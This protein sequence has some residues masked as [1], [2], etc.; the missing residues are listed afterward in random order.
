[1]INS[2]RHLSLRVI[3]TLLALSLFSFYSC[4]K[5]PEKIDYVARVNNSYLTREEFSSLVDTSS[6]DQIKK[7]D[8][9]R[10]W[11][12]SE[13]L[14]Q[15][16]EREGI[17]KDK[18]YSLILSQSAKQLAGAMLID[19]ILRYENI[20]LDQKEVKSYFDENTNE[21]R[22]PVNSFVLNIAEFIDEE[23]AIGFRNLAIESDWKKA[24]A[25]FSANQAII[26]QRSNKFLL[27][28]EINPAALS[29]LVNELYPLEISIVI[30]LKPGYYSVVQLVEKIPAGSVPAFDNIKQDV[31]KRLL[32]LKRQIFIDDFLKDLYEKNEIEIKH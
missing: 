18:D 25:Q 26:N 22:V 21:F 14:Y 1:M 9:I 10:N 27:V 8:V 13:L 3:K 30:S 11:I 15:K 5:E 6:A 28:H 20:S 19:K 32:A 4:E 23:K 12:H 24:V 7:D 29:R 31:E 17:L 2:T 16:A